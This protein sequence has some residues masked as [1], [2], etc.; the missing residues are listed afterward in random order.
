MKCFC[1]FESNDNRIYRCHYHSCGEYKNQKSLLLNKDCLD[2]IF[3]DKKIWIN[4]LSKLDLYNHFYFYDLYV[5]VKKIYPEP[6]IRLK[7]G[8]YFTRKEINDILNF[9]II[10]ELYINQQHDIGYIEKYFDNKFCGATILKRINDLKI[11]KR[12]QS[13]ATLL[14]MAKNKE[15]VRAKYGVDNISQLQSIKQKKIDTSIKHFGT[16]HHFKRKD[17]IEERRNNLTNKFGVINV[18]QLDTV[19]EIKKKTF[20]EHY[21]VDNI[22]QLVSFIKNKTFEKY[23]VEN[24]SRLDWVKEKK[25]K[26][27]I[28]DNDN[29]I[30]YSKQQ[31]DLFNE[32]TKR[33]DESISKNFKYATHG[34]EMFVI[35][36]YKC[37]SLDFSYQIGDH[38]FAIEYNGDIWHANPTKYNKD[39]KPN[40]LDKNVTAQQIWDHDKLR[41]D[42]IKNDGYDLLIVWEDEFM[43]HR[44]ETI[45]K[46]C[47]FIKEHLPEQNIN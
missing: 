14:S 26:T 3:K 28:Y 39:D 19:K 41:V 24:C 2:N 22:F 5:T 42:M 35:H 30:A 40:P 27:L 21:G 8:E 4:E 13:Q 15:T 1:G 37:F 11:Q 44:Q 6:K 34:H 12:S 23:G 9:D 7:S 17:K 33:F 38:K 32:L 29:D 16:T 47:N 18:S 25:F 45:D 31:V 20:Q 46:C 36:E 10:N 43:H